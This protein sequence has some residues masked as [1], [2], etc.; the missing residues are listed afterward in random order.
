[1]T[2]D[3][4]NLS[5]RN[6]QRRDGRQMFGWVVRS[7]RRDANAYQVFSD[8]TWGGRAQ[9]LEAALL[10]RNRQPWW[11][12]LDA[13]KS[14]N[15]DRAGQAKP[16]KTPLVVAEVARHD[17]LLHIDGKQ[18]LCAFWSASYT[19]AHGKTHTRKFSVNFWGEEA[20]LE[21]AK[22]VHRQQRRIVRALSNQ[23][24]I[25]KTRTVTQTLTTSA[26]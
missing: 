26:R 14:K 11:Q 9:A 19:D 20:A 17:S 5:L 8:G 16:S 3:T 12:P 22:A 10:W 24:A 21:K 15:K 2:Q 4:Q 1:M 13:P 18:R 25:S 23:Q 6:I 7:Q